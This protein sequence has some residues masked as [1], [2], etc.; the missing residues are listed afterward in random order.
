MYTAALPSTLRLRRL[1]R[2]GGIGSGLAI[3]L[4]SPSF[5]SRATHF[6]GQVRWYVFFHQHTVEG[7]VCSEQDVLPTL[8]GRVSNHYLTQRLREA[9]RMQDGVDQVINWGEVVN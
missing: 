7:H 6:I 3:T 1:R 9:G 8:R 4:N 5:A 2:H